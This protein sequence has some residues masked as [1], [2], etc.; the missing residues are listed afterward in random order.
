[1]LDPLLLTLQEA[2]AGRYALERELGRGGMGVVY[3]ARDVRLD[4][5][6]AIKLL[7]PEYAAN[8][9]LRERFLREA[10]TA[11]RLSHPNIVPI[12]AVEEIGDVVFYVMTYV[13][14]ETLSQRVTSRGPLSPADATRLMRELAWALGYAH[15]QGIVHRDVKPAN[16]LI[17]RSSGRA[18]LTD[19]GIAHATSIEG[20]TGAGELLGTPE[21]M[22]PEQAAGEP[23]DGRSDLYSLG[24]VAYFAVSGRLPFVAPSVR[25]IL[26]K[27][28]TELAP[29]VSHATHGLPRAL[30]AAIDKC[31]AK[32]PSDRY[33]TG[34]ALEEALG[35]SLLPAA[36][37][38]AP[39]RAFLDRR[40]IAP[41]AFYPVMS[42]AGGITLG[43]ISLPGVM[44]GAYPLVHALGA[45]GIA[46]AA[47]MPVAMLAKWMRPLLRLGYGASDIADALRIEFDRKREEY[48]YEHRALG[49]DRE[50][51]LRR[52]TAVGFLICAGSWGSVIAGAGSTAL[53]Y[54][55]MVS[56]VVFPITGLL[57]AG[58][59][60]MRTE[61]ES[62]W[63][64][65]WDGWMGRALT[66]LASIKL[67]ARTAAA[68]R[69]T[70]M[71]IA[72]NAQAL[73]DELP[74]DL[75]RAIGDAPGILR[76]LE[77]QAR[78][79]RVHVAEL[80]ESIVD[81]QRSSAEGRDALLVDLKLTRSR[82]EERLGDLIAALESVRLD[83]LRL[84]AGQAAIDGV[85]QQ[86]A[87]AEMLGAEVDR[88][89]CGQDEVQ[90]TL[91]RPETSLEPH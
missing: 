84:R 2:V 61:T 44:T 52:M 64:K 86:L 18:L 51:T 32:Y 83:L 23:I 42:I 58:A 91:R 28:I 53:I 4:R 6:V 3:L 74:R 70:E 27:Q 54:L 71:A 20:P 33:P 9:S 78:A 62:W 41:L 12:H 15:S 19:F 79:I 82:A 7:P 10:R 22:S 21:Y 45:L 57:S 35:S 38:P 11:A 48:L 46:L 66:K 5:P 17:E 50:K 76:R 43:S 90:R 68:D 77:E 1:M 56:G 67:G 14:G 31:M 30:A 65:R 69:P 34:E 73:F 59:S 89:L 60:R 16:I 85:T 81:V 29:P 36:D 49:G 40:R 80:D 39:I 55:A 37:I 47:V 63:A 26:M 87:A 72:F 13:D 75:Q 25:A 88:L 24:I 8:A